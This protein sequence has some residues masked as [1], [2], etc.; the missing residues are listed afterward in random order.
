VR[1]R[2][3]PDTPLIKKFELG[4]L[5]FL[6]KTQEIFEGG[7]NTST[8]TLTNK[9]SYTSATMILTETIGSGAAM[10]IIDKWIR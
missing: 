4:L 2:T 9:K 8:I 7:S 10:K 6:S 5:D 1:Q 3:A